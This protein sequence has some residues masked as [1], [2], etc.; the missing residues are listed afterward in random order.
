MTVVYAAKAPVPR[1]LR[2]AAWVLRK[3]CLPETA[4]FLEALAG[5]KS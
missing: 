2:R 3:A 4:A 1:K 5:G